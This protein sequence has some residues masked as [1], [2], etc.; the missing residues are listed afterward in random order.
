RYVLKF[1]QAGYPELE[2]GAHIVVQRLMYAIGYN[3]A[4]D[5]IAY[6]RREDLHLASDA[7]VTDTVGKARPLR[8]SDVDEELAAVEHDGSGVYRT[9]ASRFLPGE[10]L[11]GFLRKGVRDDDP[12]DRI[13]HEHRRV[14]RALYVFFAWLGQ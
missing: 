6:F 5:N 12:N 8:D 14:V 10:P 7:V 3:V 4:E 2:S 1:D 9:L 11:G 13:P